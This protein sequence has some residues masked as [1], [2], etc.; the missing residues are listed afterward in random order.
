MIGTGP[1][2]ISARLSGLAKGFIF[3]D[4]IFAG[5][6]QEIK[7]NTMLNLQLGI[8]HISNAGLKRPNGGMNTHNLLIGIS[9][10]NL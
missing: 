1:H 8:S 3:S 2:Y 6:M 7:G 5:V 10:T 4:N 9:K